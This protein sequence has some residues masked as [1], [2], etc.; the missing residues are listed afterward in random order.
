MGLAALRSAFPERPLTISAPISTW[1]NWVL[2]LGLLLFPIG[3]GWWGGTTLAPSIL[4]DYEMRGGA[5]PVQGQVQG[6]CST[7]YG[8]LQTCDMVVTS[9]R[10]K[11]G[12]P[13][14]Q[15]LEYMFVDPHVGRYTVQVMADPARPG[16]LTTD[17]GLNNL[18]SRTLTLLGFA[19]FGLAM[20]VAAIA[21]MRNGGREKRAMGALSGQRLTPVP[22]YVVRDREG[23]KATPAEGGATTTWHLPGKAEPF[24]LSPSQ[25]IALAVTAPGAALFPLDK[26]L[27]WADLTEEERARLRAVAEPA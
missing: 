8:L 24:W 17:M 5:I 23:W 22:A 2:G 26:D 16:Q 15:S 19:A 11:D 4:A 14:Q 27:R 20:G 7:K 18:T 21:L 12:S 9:G 13:V 10:G 1:K 25:G 3:I 6:R